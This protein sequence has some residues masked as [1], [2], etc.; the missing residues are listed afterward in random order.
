MSEVKSKLPMFD[1][2]AK[3]FDRWEIQWN[4]FTEV[5]NIT[6]GYKTQHRY[7]AEFKAYIASCGR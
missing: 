1:G 5:E 7:A 6:V 3:S 2:R 4:A